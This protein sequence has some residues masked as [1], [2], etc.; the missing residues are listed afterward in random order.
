MGMI[1]VI[2]KL[3]LD[4]DDDWDEELEEY[5]PVNQLLDYD[6]ETWKDGN[7]FEFPDLKSA[8]EFRRSCPIDFKPE[9]YAHDSQWNVHYVNKEFYIDADKNALVL[10]VSAGE[11]W[12]D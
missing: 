6:K 8:E 5:V 7:V 12:E 10:N 2:L 4:L 1:K 9:V 3:N 11:D